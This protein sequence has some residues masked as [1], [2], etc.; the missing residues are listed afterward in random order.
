ME[1]AIEINGLQKAYPGFALDVSFCVPRGSIMGLIGE[2]GAGKSTT[3]KS[4]LNLITPDAGQVRILGMDNMASEK[5]VKEQVAVVLD[6][7]TFHDTLSAD[8]VGMIMR[9]LYRRWDVTMFKRYLDK[10]A[11][12]SKK[13]IKEYSKGMKTKLSIAA[14]LSSK[15]TL[16]RLDEATAGLDP[17]VRAEI[18]DE[19]L[20]FIEDEEKAVLISSHIT[21]DLERVA[22]YLTYI[23]AGKVAISGEKHDLLESYGRVACTQ[24]Q[25]AHIGKAHLVGSRSGAYGC[26]ALVKNRKDLSFLMPDL[27]IEPASLEEIM[28][29]TVKGDA[30]C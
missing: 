6:E 25:L 3:I 20:A 12:P 30:V 4:I 21:S 28:L 26:E 5:Q 19:L 27:L 22:D 23:H 18:L 2:N 29:F 10:F 7:S 1:Y 16:L 15:P 13:A 11:L 9:S 17:V 14:A 24:A 8:E